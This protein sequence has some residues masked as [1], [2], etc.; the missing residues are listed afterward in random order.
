MSDP[1]FTA[2]M[3]SVVL[4]SLEPDGQFAFKNFSSVWTEMYVCKMGVGWKGALEM[5]Y[6]KQH[7][8]VLVAVITN[9]CFKNCQ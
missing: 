3:R 6:I 9:G 8:I 5:E 2:H 7:L 1:E 4:V